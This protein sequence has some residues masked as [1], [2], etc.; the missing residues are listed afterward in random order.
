MI[1]IAIIDDD[2]TFCDDFK[3]QIKSA[4]MVIG[5]LFFKVMRIFVPEP[6]LH[7]KMFVT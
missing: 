2:K 3:E 1:N 4:N 7:N 5:E 6:L